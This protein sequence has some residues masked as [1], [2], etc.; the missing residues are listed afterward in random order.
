MPEWERMGGQ[1]RHRSA[2]IATVVSGVLR[3][4]SICT[5]AALLDAPAALAQAFEPTAL[6]ADIPAQPLAQALEGVRPP[7]RPAAR[8]CLRCGA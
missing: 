4:L 8:L 6:A 1:S 5:P 7:D 2:G 3:A